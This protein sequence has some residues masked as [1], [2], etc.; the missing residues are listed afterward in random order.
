MPTDFLSAPRA[1]ILRYS[2]QRLDGKD[3]L[4]TIPRSV[5]TVATV[6]I[7]GTPEDG[8][9]LAWRGTDAIL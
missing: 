2:S 8:N 5:H 6:D 3:A 1:R 9:L 7:A 4:T